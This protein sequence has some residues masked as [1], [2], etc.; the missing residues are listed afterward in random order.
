MHRTLGQ[1]RLCKAIVNRCA[2]RGKIGAVPQLR[3]G[4]GLDWSAECLEFA[5]RIAV[6]EDDWQYVEQGTW[7]AGAWAE[8]A[9]LERRLN[10]PSR[11]AL[12]LARARGEARALPTS[13]EKRLAHLGIARSLV[14]GGAWDDAEAQAKFLTA[15]QQRILRRWLQD[16]R[17]M[18]S[19]RAP[20]VAENGVTKL[21][22]GRA[23]FL[24][25]LALLRQYGKL[26]RD[27]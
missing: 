5:R 13:H 10:R 25:W 18:G 1:Q 23:R 19:G 14:L 15:P 8:L 17:A 26:Q 9:A 6:A 12:S 16:A 22:E 11:A 7:R 27:R 4:K 2:L 20:V 24:G 21:P 3:R